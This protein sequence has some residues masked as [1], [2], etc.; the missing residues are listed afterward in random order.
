[1]KSKSKSKNNLTQIEELCF[2]EEVDV[3]G[4]CEAPVT[5]TTIA[6]FSFVDNLISLNEP[7]KKELHTEGK[8]PKPYGI[9]T[10]VEGEYFDTKRSFSF[11][12]STVRKYKQQK[13]S[14]LL[15]IN[16]IVIDFPDYWVSVRTLTNFVA[17]K[18][19]R[20]LF[21]GFCNLIYKTNFINSI[22]K[23]WWRRA[24]SNRCP[25]AVIPKHLRAQ[26][27]F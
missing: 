20:Q 5:E 4:I 12:K 15:P 25:K 18:N 27:I 6:E 22:G 14:A 26:S 10:P 3:N 2:N 9:T 21:R 11:R 1:M 16:Y 7:I 23:F 17:Q 24:V 13:S 19:P 8:I